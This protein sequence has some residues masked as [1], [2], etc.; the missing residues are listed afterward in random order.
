MR[1]VGS[2]AAHAIGELDTRVETEE[3]RFLHDGFAALGAD[4]R[5]LGP[6]WRE[7]SPDGESATKP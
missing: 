6:R 3:D 1:F 7:K 5:A 4:L 2:L